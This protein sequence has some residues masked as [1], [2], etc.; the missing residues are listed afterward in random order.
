MSVSNSSEMERAL[1]DKLM[2]HFGKTAEEASETEMLKACAL[3]IRD[4]MA[5]QEVRQEKRL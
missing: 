2:I 4:R 1:I 3:V 5:I